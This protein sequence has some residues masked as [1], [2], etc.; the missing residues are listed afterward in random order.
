LNILITGATGFI[1]R[2][3][4]ARLAAR[5]HALVG[6]SRNA[7]SAQQSVPHLQKTFSWDPAREYPPKEAFAGVDAVVHLAGEGVVGRWTP[8][9]KRAV[10]GSRVE[11]TRHLIAMMNKLE[12]KPSV[13]VCASAI[14]FYGDRADERLDES[15]QAGNG[16]LA[17]VCKDWEAQAARAE[18]IRTATLRV[19]IVLGRNGGALRPM[20]LPAKLGL[21]G[22]L[23]SG[24]QWW[25]WVHLADVH[26]LIEHA[27]SNENVS[28]PLNATAPNPARQKEFAKALGHVLRRPAFLPAPAFAIKLL[29]GEFSFELLSSKRAWPRAA[30]DSGYAFKY[31]DLETALCEILR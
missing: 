31:P 17:E 11:G 6:L 9:K 8:A 12:R 30:L 18:G 21:G 7:S 1:G 28:G 29:L 16:F 14:G 13:L 3:L 26:G 22:P 25:S 5:G 24:K 15:S 10:Y 4:C 19:G 23:G 27:L 2:S 20:L